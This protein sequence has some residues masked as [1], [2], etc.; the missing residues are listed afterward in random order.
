METCCHSNFSEKPSAEIDVKNSWSKEINDSY[1]KKRICRII[2]FAVLAD[3]RINLKEYEN[4]DKYLNLAREVTIILIVMGAFGTVIK[5]FLKRLRD[6]V[7]VRVE[8]IPTTTLLSTARIPRRVLETWGDLLSL[9]LLWK[10][11]S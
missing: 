10:T 2:D 6:L 8:T 1:N 7:R 3:H 4:T 9:K 11:I 5:G